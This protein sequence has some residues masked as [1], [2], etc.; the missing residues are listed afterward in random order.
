MSVV[1][2]LEICESIKNTLGTAEGILKA[3]G[4]DEITEGLED[5]PLIQVYWAGFEK[6]SGSNTDRRT[7]G[8]PQCKPIRQTLHNIRV[9]VVAR[10]RSHVNLDMKAIAVTAHAV[11]TVLEEQD[12]TPYFG[13]SDIKAFRYSCEYVP[14]FQS[15]DGIYSGERF[16]IEITLF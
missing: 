1:T 6:S 16:T 12:V 11:D 9:D 7:F 14:N 2:I 13:N 4:M 15:G 5:L 8:T 3:Q 10:Q